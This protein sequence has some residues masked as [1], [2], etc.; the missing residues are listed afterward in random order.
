MI[1]RLIVAIINAF[2]GLRNLWRRL[3]R[4]RV[5]IVVMDLGGEL[6][7]FS[8][9]IPLWQ[10]LMK[11]G[12]DTVSVQELRK[13]FAQI[14]ADPNTRGVLLRIQGLETGWAT[15]QSVRDEIAYLRSRG[16]QV[17]AYVISGDTPSMFVASAADKILIPPPSM[18]MMMGFYHET[19][20]L[21]DAFAKIGLS[22]EVESVSPYKSAGEAY[23]RTEMSPENREQIERLLDGR[24]EM[25]V[26][27]LSES[28]NLT[29]EQVKQLI[30]TAPLNANQALQGGLVDAALYDDQ[31]SA[32]FTLNGEEPI[33]EEWY[34]ARGSLRILPRKFRSKLVGVVTVEGT[35]MEGKSRNVP[36]PIPMFGGQQAGSESVI[37]AL[38]TAEKN[39]R[40]AAL[41]VYVDSPGGDAFASDL[42]W[43]EVYRIRQKL[44]VV[45][46]MG[47]AAASGGYYIAAAA[48][49]IVAQ[50]M[51]L[52]GSIGVVMLRP[53]IAG[54]LEKLDV[55]V[56]RIRRGER[57]GLL[58][59][60][61]PPSE[62]ERKALR[63]IMFSTYDQFKQRVI[64]GRKL[65]EEQLE[66]IAGGR[67]WLG[68]TAKELGLVDRL[69]GITSAL[70]YAQELAG[71]PV[72]RTAPMLLIR[73]KDDEL[74]PEP[75]PVA[76]PA[77]LKYEAAK[78]LQPRIA[79]IAPFE[80]P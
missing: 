6:P 31:L 76:S 60:S 54:M 18:L 14:A 44:P 64:E 7:Q 2:I 10:R 4:R 11:Q 59:I 20:F 5:D 46:A 26:T 56:E 9:K 22:F 70:T 8:Q 61:N 13:R 57:S 25:F 67:V 28:R 1:G 33:I 12:E 40:L 41:V 39:P 65:S 72:D 73:A 52:T 49:G 71:L 47:D 36:L 69:G 27:A 37:Q 43:R 32:Y 79:A 63:N 45:V 55:N 21:K 58:S 74:Q 3:W 80:L 38:R 16:K 29:P 42:M 53:I 78:V 15:L 50:P 23:I 62:E 51:T 75:F 35:I 66:P 19:Q 68:N 17:W 34:E 24:Y 30:D 48:S 77:A